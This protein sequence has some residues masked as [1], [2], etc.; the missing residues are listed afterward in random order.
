[1]RAERV[2]TP[3]QFLEATT[4]LRSCDPLRTNVLGSV[5][6][7]IAAGMPWRGE[8]FWWVLRDGDA[9]LGAAMRTSPFSLSLSPMPDEALAALAEAVLAVDPGLPGVAG[10]E[11]SVER[12]LAA[13][14]SKGGPGRGQVA[15]SQPQLLYE[16]AAVRQPEVE[17]RFALAVPEDLDAV[18]LPWFEAFEAE[19]DGMRRPGDDRRAVVEASVREGRVGLWRLDGRAVSLAGHAMPVDTP[20][21]VVT[22]VGPVYTPPERR[23]RGFA[24]AVTGA[25][26]AAI[27]DRGSR[28]I[29]Y[30]D[31]LNPTSNHVYQDLGYELVDRFEH[32]HFAAT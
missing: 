13:S 17:G 26:T 2:A 7:S 4:A 6:G 14:E 15:S 21:G 30:T 1:M 3:E 28:A 29:L 27:L 32:V 22:R 16:A 24:G 31:A 18:V 20:A 9:V 19:V 25:V 8:C 10:F 23:R 5:A 12:Y 11:S